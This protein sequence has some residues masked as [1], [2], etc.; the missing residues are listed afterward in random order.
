VKDQPPYLHYGADDER[1]A[2]PSLPTEAASKEVPP[3]AHPG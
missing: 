2:S 1:P 3:H